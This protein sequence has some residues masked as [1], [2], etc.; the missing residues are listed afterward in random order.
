MFVQPSLWMCLCKL[1]GTNK[2]IT[3]GGGGI[4]IGYC[5]VDDVFAL[6]Q[7]LVLAEGTPDPVVD[8]AF[9]KSLLADILICSKISKEGLNSDTYMANRKLGRVVK[10][11]N[12]LS[13]ASD[14][15]DRELQFNV[16]CLMT[17]T[18]NV[19][20]VLEAMEGI[21]LSSL[22]IICLLLVLS[23]LYLGQRTSGKNGLI[24]C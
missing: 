8:V 4:S 9:A 12:D 22:H 21:S 7:L 19:L 5:A 2:T 20:S 17:F 3:G 13:K 11:F 24:E 18:S 10:A 23:V 1:A 6:N 14:L 16:R 15:E